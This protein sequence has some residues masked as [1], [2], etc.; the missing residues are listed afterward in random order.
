M[1]CSPRELFEMAEIL[2][3]FR[4]RR[5]EILRNP[6]PGPPLADDPLP[7]R[8]QDL[9]AEIRPDVKHVQMH[10]A[11]GWTKLDPQNGP[12]RAGLPPHAGLARVFPPTPPG[13]PP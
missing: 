3:C 12:R 8:L 6:H 5:T 13:I 4:H 10:I 11:G 2:H 7:F 9:F 1:T